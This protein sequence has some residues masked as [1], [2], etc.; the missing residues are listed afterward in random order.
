[1]IPETEGIDAMSKEINQLPAF[2]G[3]PSNEVLVLLY[4]PAGGIEKTKQTTRGALLHDVPRNA[5]AAS[6]TTATVETL[7]ATSGIRATDDITKI[8]HASGSIAIPTAA[9]GAQVTVNK[10]VTGAAVGDSVILTMPSSAPAGL[11]CRAAVSAADT[12]TVLAFNAT[13]GSISGASYAAAILVIG[14]RAAP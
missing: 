5:G 8:L 7:V 13:G 6:F 2:S 3:D 4:D 14:H 12:V 10:A 9:S 1:M 11:I